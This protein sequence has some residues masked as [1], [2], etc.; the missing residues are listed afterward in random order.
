MQLDQS[1]FKAYDIRGIVGKSLDEDVFYAIGAAMGEVYLAEGQSRVLVACDGRTSSPSFK[2][3]LIEGLAAHPLE[4][5]DIGEAASPVAYFGAARF[6]DGNAL[7]VTASHNPKQY[8]GLKVMLKHLPFHGEE[9]KTLGLAAAKIIPERRPVAGLVRTRDISQTYIDRF[10]SGIR[11]QRKVRLALDCGNG[12]TGP[13][14]AK[15]LE[16][17]NCEVF[18]LFTEVDGDFPNHEA[19]PSKAKNL[20][21][22]VRCVR[23]NACEIGIAFDGDGDRVG[24]VTSKGKLIYP[25]RLLM[26]FARAILANQPGAPVVYDIKCSRRLTQVIEQAGGVPMMEPTGHSF[27]QSA[28][29]RNKAPVGGEM[30]GHIFFNDGRGIGFDDGMY[31]AARLLEIV[32]AHPDATALL[33]ALPDA[34]NTPEIQIPVEEGAAHAIVER[35][36]REARFAENPEIKTIDGIRLD[37]ADGFALCRASNTTPII[38]IRMEGDNPAALRRIAGILADGL[39]PFLEGIGQTIRNQACL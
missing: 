3:A 32:S 13:I 26:L 30:S 38:V 19:D 6:T 16:R 8:N 1:I 25:D 12:I 15:I 36:Q 31:A 20:E 29:M 4:I 11:M 34:V 21:Q 28:I 18:P 39:E 27:I 10:Y 14:A 33:E 23:D 7:V 9:L 35:M 5:L 2:S 24:V 22:L 37:F 17:L